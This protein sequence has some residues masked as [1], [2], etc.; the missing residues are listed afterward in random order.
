MG[1]IFRR[2][3]SKICFS[4]GAGSVS[5]GEGKRAK[6]RQRNAKN[7]S[8]KVG[9]LALQ[10]AVTEHLE[11]LS[12]CGA[13]GVPIKHPGELASVEA[14]I[15]P[16]GESTTI[17][18][19]ISKYGFVGEI[20]KLTEKGAPIYGSCAGLILLAQK[21]AGSSQDTVKK[22]Q[23]SL[24]FMDIVVKRNAFGRQKESFEIDLDVP[25]LGKEPFRAVFIRAP[26]IEKLNDGALA[27]AKFEDKVVMARQGKFLVTA[28]HP[29]LTNDT[30]V[31]RY[32]LK[33]AKKRK[34]NP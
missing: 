30:R 3:P 28:F 21:I 26:W 33:M 17:G 11:M 22:E 34:F 6:S 24:K 8:I 7:N 20:Q 32:F 29:E 9:V 15:I 5:K 19:L 13:E 23:L 16:G 18:K 31:H 12:E 4:D 27:L 25:E 10:G 2:Y 14:L 1:L